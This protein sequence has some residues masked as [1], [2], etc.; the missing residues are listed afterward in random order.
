MVDLKHL[1]RQ[2]LQDTTAEFRFGQEEAINSVLNPPHRA[3]VVQA[4]GWGKS[5]VYFI[6][7]RVLRDQGKGPTLV[8]S[9]LL[10]LMRDQ[11][12]AAASLGLR[13]EQYTS[14]NSNE[15]ADIEAKLKANRVDLLLVSPE[16]LA[17]SEFRNLTGASSLAKAGLVVID[18][19][20]CISDWGHDFRPDYQ[21]IGE[22]IRRLPTT[23]VLATTATANTRVVDDIKAQF[24]SNIKVLRGPLVRES[25]RLQVVAERD[26]V[27]RLAWLADHLS[28]LPSSGIIYA[29]TQRDTERV[30]TWL[31]NVGYD[32]AAYH[33]G[34][35]DE[36]KIELED[37]L[38]RNEVKALVATVALGMGFDKPDLGFVVHYQSPGNLVAYYQ[39]IGRAGRAIPTAVAVLFMGRE[40][41]SI[42]EWFIASSRPSEDNIRAVLKALDE[43]PLSLSRLVERLNLTRSEIDKVL[44]TL[45]AASTSPIVKVQHSYQRTPN[46]YVYDEAHTHALAQ[47]RRE[48]RKRFVAFARTSDCLMQ[49]VSQELDDDTAAPCGKCANCIGYEVVSSEITDTRQAEAAMFLRRSEFLIEPRKRWQVN[50]FTVDQFTGNIS[51]PQRCEVGVCLSNWGDPGVATWVQEDKV[52]GSFRD[53]IVDAAVQ[54]IQRSDTLSRIQWVCAVPSRRSGDLVPSF[55]RRLAYALNLEYV[56]AVQKVKDTPAQKEQQNSFYQAH[57][58]DGAFKVRE[59]REGT[60]LLIDDMVDSRWTFTVVGALLRNAGSGPI[61]PFALCSTGHGDSDE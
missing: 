34:L 16:R 57:N 50:A 24:G 60:A 27:E 2:S 51:L 44:K 38:M 41:E 15:W 35:A 9:P 22:L 13:A 11:L 19:A 45:S 40:D 47:R 4:T 55:A 54:V 36:A 52:I 46:P 17:N 12:K 26:A 28:E 33:S 20:H 6:A 3:L 8:I 49:I 31:R 59:V 29:L 39:Q 58:L 43:E 61:V 21:R 32:V 5:I 23:A 1:L 14:S 7:T 53:N 10:S 48:E 25:L 56:E 42:H 37:K 18:E 30:A